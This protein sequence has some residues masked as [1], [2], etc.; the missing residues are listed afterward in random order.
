[1]KDPSPFFLL[2]SPHFWLKTVH[3]GQNLSSA[4]INKKEAQPPSLPV[5]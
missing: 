5:T 1:M 2:I 4:P 3:A